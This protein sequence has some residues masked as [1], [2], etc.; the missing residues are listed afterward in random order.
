MATTPAIP[1]QESGFD[2][3]KAVPVVASPSPTV[4][5]APSTEGPADTDFDWSNAKSPTSSAPIAPSTGTVPATP[6]AWDRFSSAFVKGVGVTPP[7]N[8]TEHIIDTLT[9]NTGA[10]LVT[11][12]AAK[13]LIDS[14]S[15]AMEAKKPE[16]FERAK[17]DVQQAVADFHNKDYRN[18]AAS[19]GSLA[20]DVVSGAGGPV[21]S[22]VG[23]R[24][25]SISEGTRPGG[26]LATPLG[27]TAADVTNAAVASAVGGMG[28]AEAAPEAAVETVG[29]KEATVASNT[30]KSGISAGTP[31]T[32]VPSGEN[33]QPDLH[34]G[35]RNFVNNTNA[36]NG[37]PPVP[38]E[39]NVLD[40]AQNQADAFQTRSQATFGK[41]QKITGI[42]PTALKKILSSRTDQ[43]ENLLAAGKD[44]EAGNL[45]Q[46]QLNDENRMTKAFNDAKAKGVDVDQA[47]S[48]WNRSLRAD[49]LSN[50]VRGSKSNVSTLDNPDIDPNKLTSRLQKLYESQPGGKTAK[51]AQLGG[52]Q[53]AA[54]LVEHA[55]NARDATQVIKDFEPQSATGQQALSKIISDN[56]GEKSSLIKGGK[57][58]AN[59]DWNGVVKDIGNLTPEEQKAFGPELGQ[60]RQF[61]G[62]QALKQNAIGLLKRGVL[63]GTAGATGFM[64]YEAAK[65]AIGR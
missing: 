13:A 35:I 60:V 17:Q 11:Y 48:D 58:V 16:A 26:D 15:N 9:G 25:R 54:T 62:K 3:S 41:V 37:L 5:V 63:V 7:Q 18:F 50:A 55:E 31:E 28:S 45:Q 47:R 1:Q 38:D 6:S 59:T 57:V 61:A 44:E 20:G 19:F 36:E 21:A 8:A 34:Q 29:P 14:V 32:T 22:Q 2:W 4:T 10:G 46:L 65:A 53:N 39:V 52:D 64:G 33:I 49:E 51:L 56:T 40:A 24:I 43:I 23:S 30:A 27:E 42:D 12:R